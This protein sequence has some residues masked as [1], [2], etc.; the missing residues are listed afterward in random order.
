M[1]AAEPG[2]PPLLTPTI[3]IPPTEESTAASQAISAVINGVEIGVILPPDWQIDEYHG[4]LMVEHT[5]ERYEGMSVYLF[6]PPMDDF[7]LDDAA[8]HENVA[9]ATL[10]EVVQTPNIIGT[11]VAIS[12]PQH[13]RWDDCDAAYYLLTSSDGDRSLVMALEVT[14]ED[15]LVVLNITVPEDHTGSIREKLPILLDGLTINGDRLSGMGL[16][17]LPDPL[18]FPVY[19]SSQPETAYSTGD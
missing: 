14:D 9:L 17:E 4:L 1:K 13:F 15:R 6:V 19:E 7:S 10:R 12:E 2:T 5:G 16:E 8:P 3:A 11:N 18:P